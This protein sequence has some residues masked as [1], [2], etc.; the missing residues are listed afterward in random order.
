MHHHRAMIRHLDAEVRP[1]AEADPVQLL[2][3][4]VGTWHAESVVAHG[5]RMYPAQHAG[6]IAGSGD[7]IVGHVSYRIDGDGCEITSISADPQ[8][9][10]TGT[11]LLRAVIETASAAHCHRVWLTTTNDNLDALRFYQRRGFRLAALRPGAVERARME[12][13]PEIPEVGS[14]GIRMRDELDLELD[15]RSAR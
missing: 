2:R 8:G 6:F 11:R 12:L 13:K 9:A 14:F 7:R 1:A 5:E 3:Y 10:G 4:I 15:P